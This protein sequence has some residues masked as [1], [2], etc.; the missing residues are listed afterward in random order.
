M[1]RIMLLALGVAA[2]ALGV[3]ALA[4]PVSAQAVTVSKTSG[5]VKADLSYVKRGLFEY[6]AVGL[7][8]TRAGQVAQ[9]GGVEKGCRECPVSPAET[10]R[11]ESL[12]LR[13]L[14]ADA[15]PEVLLRLYTGGA[16]CC[17]QLMIYG[18]VPETGTYARAFTDFGNSDYELED[19]NGDG[20]LELRGYDDSA[21]Y[22]FT[23]YAGSAFP[24]RI[25]AYR[26]RAL[27]DVTREFPA[28]VERDA[29]RW[30]RAYRSSSRLLSEFPSVRRARLVAY[31]ADL[32]LLGRSAEADRFLA[33][34]AK[35]SAVKRRESGWPS[36]PVFVR[37]VE[38]YLKSAGYL[39]G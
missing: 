13:D 32:H 17:T 6:R 37:A 31:L 29:A 16:H 24:I 38:A 34:Q 33:A 30:L 2:L 27:V 18:F 12:E 21:A 39:P 36:G 25:R 23:S 14:D 5:V 28:L 7:T 9:S 11:G 35:T 19:L 26:N 4:L 8:I 20:T 10:E 1:N 15:E 22:A 3:A